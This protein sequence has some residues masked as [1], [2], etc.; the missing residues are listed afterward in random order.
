[1]AVRNRRPPHINL[2]LLAMHDMPCMK[3]T[4]D[5]GIRGGTLVST[6]E[7]IQT[8]EGICN[9]CVHLQPSRSKLLAY[10]ETG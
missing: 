10:K 4:T 2:I 5:K 8:S 1:M 7:G 3:I 9:L 6:A